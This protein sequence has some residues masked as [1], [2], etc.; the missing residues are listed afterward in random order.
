MAVAVVLG[1][2]AAAAVFETVHP[3]QVEEEWEIEDLVVAVGAETIGLVVIMAVGPA[4]GTEA[5]M[6]DPVAVLADMDPEA[7]ELVIPLVGLAAQAPTLERVRA[8]VGLVGKTSHQV[9]AVVQ[10]GNLM[11]IATHLVVTPEAGVMMIIPKKHDIK[12]TSLTYQIIPALLDI[13]SVI[14][15]FPLFLSLIFHI[16]KQEVMFFKSFFVIVVG[17]SSLDE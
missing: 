7:L 5:L 12:Y 9:L 4:E 14:V 6:I 3:V 16:Q 10:N 17:I 8:K 1:R 13:E 2:A 11:T 15:R